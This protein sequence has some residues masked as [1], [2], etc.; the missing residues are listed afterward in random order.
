MGIATRR[1]T[2]GQLEASITT[3]E[4][5]L[6]RKQID[7]LRALAQRDFRPVTEDPGSYYLCEQSEVEVTSPENFGPIRG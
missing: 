5:F 3:F 2:A 6:V 4:P 1:G 7:V